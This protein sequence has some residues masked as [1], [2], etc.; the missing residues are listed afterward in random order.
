MMQF[1]PRYQ[2][3]SQPPEYECKVLSQRRSKLVGLWV[4]DPKST[5]FF[6]TW[7]VGSQLPDQGLNLGQGS[8]SLES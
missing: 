8:E 3:L 2:P 4:P 1:M 7:L 6:G 5:F